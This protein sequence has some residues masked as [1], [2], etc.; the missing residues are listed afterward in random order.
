MQLNSALVSASAREQNPLADFNLAQAVA[1]RAQNLC[2]CSSLALHHCAIAASSS[3]G[4]PPLAAACSRRCRPEPAPW[5]QRSLEE[6]MLLCPVQHSSAWHMA[7]QLGTALMSCSRVHPDLLPVA[8]RPTCSLHIGPL[9]PPPWLLPVAALAVLPA[10]AR[11]EPAPARTHCDGPCCRAVPHCAT[12][13]HAAL[14]SRGRAAGPAALRLAAA[15]RCSVARAQPCSSSLLASL[16]GSP[17]NLTHI[18]LLLFACCWESVGPSWTLLGE[19]AP[20]TGRRWGWEPSHFNY[21]RNVILFSATLIE[22]KQL[23]RSGWDKSESIFIPL[24][25]NED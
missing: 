4:C 7:A 8:P 19:T 25:F 15:G 10:C 14:T 11:C 3:V 21:C 18:C 13:C 22:I 5:W 12:L 17:T 6:P 9:P 23:P 24:W 1:A 2:V 16:G 20:C